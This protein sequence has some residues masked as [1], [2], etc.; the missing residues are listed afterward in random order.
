MSNLPEDLSYQG[1]ERLMGYSDYT[2]NC[3]EVVVEVQKLRK[4]DEFNPY[5]EI[6]ENLYEVIGTSEFINACKARNAYQMA[7][8][9]LNALDNYRAEEVLFA[10]HCNLNERSYNNSYNFDDW[11]DA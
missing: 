5:V 1:I 7:S 3:P 2:D 10:A 9:I 6:S 11:R 4:T 8:I